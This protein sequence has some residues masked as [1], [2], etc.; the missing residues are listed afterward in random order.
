MTSIV[1]K[2]ELSFD[3]I[4]LQAYEDVLEDLPPSMPTNPTY[5]TCYHNWQSL[6]PEETL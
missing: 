6:F 5:M 1:R 3:E 2:G 4:N